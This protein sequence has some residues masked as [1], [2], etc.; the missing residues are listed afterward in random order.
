MKR[1]TTSLLLTLAVSSSA[2]AGSYQYGKVTEVATTGDAVTFQLDTT[3]GADIRADNC[4]ADTLNFSI[5]FATKAAAKA[6]FDIV[7][8]SKRTGVKIGVNGDGNCW[9]NG[10]FENADSIAF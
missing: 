4:Q 2:F 1:I 3:D 7:M 9:A 8:E 6:M 10:E 5:N